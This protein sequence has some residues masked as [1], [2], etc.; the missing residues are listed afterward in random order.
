MNWHEDSNLYLYQRA[1]PVSSYRHGFNG[2]TK[3][4]LIVKI[5]KF[6]FYSQHKYSKMSSWQNAEG[7]PDSAP[8]ATPEGSLK[9]SSQWGKVQPLVWTR[10]VRFSGQSRCQSLLRRGRGRADVSGRSVKYT[11]VSRSRNLGFVHTRCRKN[12]MTW[13]M[14]QKQCTTQHRYIL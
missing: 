4:L 6:S 12:D 5:K 2:W 3:T 13:N 8:K 11:P 14:I 7:H 1:V 9:T 10:T